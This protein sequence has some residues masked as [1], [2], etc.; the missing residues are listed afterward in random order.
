MPVSVQIS[1]TGE[2]ANQIG[3]WPLCQDFISEVLF[4]EV[5]YIARYFS[6]NYI[7]FST[8]FFWGEES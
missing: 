1:G 2:V 5:A 3:R 6:C 4:L 7:S 8:D